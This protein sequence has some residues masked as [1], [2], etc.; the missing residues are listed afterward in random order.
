MPG[1]KPSNS[2]LILLYLAD[3]FC[4]LKKFMIK[5][6]NL[7][8]KFGSLTAVDNISFEIKKGEIIGLL[9][10]NGAGKTTTMRLLVGYLFP[11]KGEV[12]INDQSPYKKRTQVLSQ[13]G[14]LPENNPLYPDQKVSEYL[15]FISQAKSSKN[16]D[17]EKI[18]IDTG[19]E[20]VLDKKIE[21]LSRGYKQRVGLA[22][23][24]LGNP[25]ITILDEPTS[26]LDPIEQENIRNL[27]KKL[28]KNRVVIF[29]THVLAEAE[30]IATRIIIIHQGKIAFDKLKP[31]KKGSLA[32]IFKDLVIV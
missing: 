28:S 7:T 31:K 25:L 22:A 11:S 26:G 16:D 18:I 2:G 5:I 8:K 12:K 6:K 20:K 21:N 23:A 19:L 15:D 29:S 1:K 14:Y 4:I 13:I 30:A 9:G 27:I 3:F 32:K 17:L 10:L 24:L